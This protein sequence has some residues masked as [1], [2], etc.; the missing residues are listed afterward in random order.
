MRGPLLNSLQVQSRIPLTP[1]LWLFGTVRT[2]RV[3]P[4]ISKTGLP[5]SYGDICILI[6]AAYHWP[7]ESMITPS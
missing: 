6:E 7:L 4:Q 3:P 5:V 2:M 1:A